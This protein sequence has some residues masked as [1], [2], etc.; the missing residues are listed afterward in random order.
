MLFRCILRALAEDPQAARSCECPTAGLTGVLLLHYKVKV[1]EVCSLL[2]GIVSCQARL[3]LLLAEALD[4]QMQT[5]GVS[6][7]GTRPARTMQP[8]DDDMKEATARSQARHVTENRFV[9]QQ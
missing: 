3:L 4:L 8:L 2:W 1:L 7:W 9:G 6:Q 5:G